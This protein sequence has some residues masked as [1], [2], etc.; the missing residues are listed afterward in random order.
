MRTLCVY[1]G[2]SRGNHPD[3][4]HAVRALGSVIAE[5]GIRLVYGGASVGIMGALADVV[6]AEGGSVVGIIPEHLVRHEV[7]HQQLSD[8][9]VVASMHERKALMAELSDAF[10][11]LPGGLGTIE[12]LFEM[13]TWAQL[14]L[15]RK[16]CGVLNV[17][18]Y[19]DHLLAFLDHAEAEQ[20]VRPHHRAMLQVA[21]DAEAL[22]AALARYRAPGA[23]KWT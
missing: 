23:Q 9:R 13:L 18:G 19:F 21:D 7:A 8:L 6:L 17:R 14:D 1:C 16:P 20:F 11:A 22:L 15:H 10:V 4:L 3:Y 12:E 5:R 2:S